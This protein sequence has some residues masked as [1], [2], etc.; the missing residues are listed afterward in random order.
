MF[1]KV[2]DLFEGKK[3]YIV[4]AIGVIVALAGHFFGPFGVG[5][6]QIP[7]MEW[8]Q[9]WAVVWQSGLFSALRAGVAKP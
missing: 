9:V 6:V 8:T 5:E 1:D 4:S 7:K 3:T 2:A